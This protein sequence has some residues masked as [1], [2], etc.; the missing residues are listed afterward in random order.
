MVAAP[1]QSVE[2]TAMAWRA[3]ISIPDESRAYD[4]QRSFSLERKRLS[5]FFWISDDFQRTD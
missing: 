1:R 5:L 4:L 2:Y 3:A